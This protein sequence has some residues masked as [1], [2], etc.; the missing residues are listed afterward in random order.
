MQWPPMPGPGVNFMKPNGLVAAASMTSHTSTPSLSQMIAISLTR[1]MFTMRKV[2][3]S[4]L[5]SSAASG[6]ET[7]TMRVD[8]GAVERRR[9]RACSRA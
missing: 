6:D 4:S 5:T 9:D 7:G 3:S 8:A 2:F 1:P